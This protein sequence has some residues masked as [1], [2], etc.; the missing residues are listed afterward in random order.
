MEKN[1]RLFNSTSFLVIVGLAGWTKFGLLLAPTFGRLPGFEKLDSAEVRDRLSVMVLILLIAIS[2]FL[3]RQRKYSCVFENPFI[4]G[5]TALALWISMSTYLLDDDVEW[6]GLGTRVSTACVLISAFFLFFQLPLAKSLKLVISKKNLIGVA[7]L[8]IFVLVYL[9]SLI[10]LNGGLIDLFAASTIFNELLLPIT[11]VTPLGNFASQYTSML[12]WPLLAIKNLS[13]SN[14]MSAVLIW[15]LVLTI[16]QLLTIAA[17]GK[18]V[19]RRVPFAVVLLISS[20]LILMKGE[21]SNEITGS[22]VA[23]FFSIPSRTFFP[24]V[25]CLVLGFSLFSSTK[26]PINQILLGALLPI[27]AINNLEFG[28]P[29]V[30]SALVVVLLAFREKILTLREVSVVCVS[31]VI[32]LLLVIGGYALRSAPL[33]I[34]LWTAMVRAQGS[35]G[36]MN[37]A[38]K[39][40][41][42]Y[43]VVFAMLASSFLIGLKNFEQTQNLD[44]LRAASITIFA[45]MWGVLSMPFFTG[46]SWPSHIQIYFIPVAICIFGV[47]GICYHSKYLSVKKLSIGDALRQLPLLMTLVLPLGTFL[48]APNPQVEWKRAFGGG[49]EWSYQSQSKTKSVVSVEEAI[50]RYDLDVARGVYFGDQYA[51]TVQLITGLRNGLGINTVEYSLVSA[52]LRDLACRRLPDLNPEFIIAQND[53][54]RMNF[55]GPS[56]LDSSCPGMTVLHAPDDIGITVFGYKRPGG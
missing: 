30:L 39:V 34:E 38:M 41:D 52:E 25:V 45:S 50:D 22:I 48:I 6:A 10:Q 40:I 44:V 12:G 14:I 4:T 55:L 35:G 49:S 17:I 51:T 42:T 23:G 7:S 20:S 3:N 5:F 43:L 1:L 37:V 2:F 36:Y 47:V 56:R 54:S 15:L 29:A 11:G 8:G 24:I 16:A 27:T 53:D 28:T 21:K 31:T 19:F 9:P 18:F 32:S 46:R 13:A 33:S 26:R